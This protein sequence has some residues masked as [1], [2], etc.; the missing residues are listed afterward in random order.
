MFALYKQAEYSCHEKDGIRPKKRIQSSFVE[1]SICE[2]GFHIYLL[3]MPQKSDE[4]QWVSYLLTV[5]L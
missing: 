3:V 1:I 4:M 2:N 5:L